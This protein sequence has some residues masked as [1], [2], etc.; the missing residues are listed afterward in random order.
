VSSLTASPRFWQERR[1]LALEM[2]DILKK[3]ASLFCE[4]FGADGISKEDTLFLIEGLKVESGFEYYGKPTADAVLLPVDAY[5]PLP[6]IISGAVWAVKHGVRLT[7]DA[8]STNSVLLSGVCEILTHLTYP[9][10]ITPGK[11]AS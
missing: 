9:G 6:L 5:S 10:F 3:N 11:D 4:L 1:E 8:P 7:V 2:T